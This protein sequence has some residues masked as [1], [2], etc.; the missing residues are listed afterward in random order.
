MFTSLKIIQ[1]SVN[2]NDV[3]ATVSIYKNTSLYN[4]YAKIIIIT[5]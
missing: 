5:P 3:N 4:N 1:Y 2:I